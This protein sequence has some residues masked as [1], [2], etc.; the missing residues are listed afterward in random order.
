MNAVY[1]ANQA[2]MFEGIP[3]NAVNPVPSNFSLPS[4]EIPDAE[5]NDTTVTK[6]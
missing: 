4:T 3:V 2:P 1:L 6:S 5:L